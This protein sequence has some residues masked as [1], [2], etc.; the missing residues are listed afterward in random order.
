M[1]YEHHVDFIASIAALADVAVVVQAL[2]DAPPGN[3]NSWLIMPHCC[4]CAVAMGVADIPAVTWPV[5]Q[6]RVSGR[7]AVIF[8]RCGAGCLL[9]RCG[10]WR[11]S[12]R[13]FL[14]R[15]NR[16]KPALDMSTSP[17]AGPARYDAV[18]EDITPGPRVDAD[19]LAGGA[20]TAGGCAPTRH[21]GTAAD[22]QAVQLHGSQLPPPPA[23]QITHHPRPDDP[24][25][26][27]QHG[28]SSKALPRLSIGIV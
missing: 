14:L 23:K 8:R 5:C 25:I 16:S 17:L 21:S 22:R 1:R 2:L 3:F 19:V 9:R 24:A 27:L 18:S 10:G 4:N 28:S 20:I 26:K 15:T 12:C 7:P 6:S 11:R 13:H